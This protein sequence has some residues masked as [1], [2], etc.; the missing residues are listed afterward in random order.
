MKKK[1]KSLFLGGG[2]LNDK[3]QKRALLRYILNNEGIS[4]LLLLY[5]VCSYENVNTFSRFINMTKCATA[6]TYLI[7]KLK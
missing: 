4:I 2:G 1:L 5:L 3:T 7:V 6:A